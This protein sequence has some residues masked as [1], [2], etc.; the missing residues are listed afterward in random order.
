MSHRQVKASSNILKKSLLDVEN[1]D[2][3]NIS[4]S[5]SHVESEFESE[6]HAVN[7]DMQYKIHS[8]QQTPL[9]TLQQFLADPKLL[10]KPG[11]PTTNI[12]DQYTKRCYN[13]PDKRIDKFMLLT[14]ACRFMSKIELMLNEK[15]NIDSSGIMLD[16]DVYQD[17]EKDQF[18]D[19]I[20]Q[21]LIQH[22]C[23]LFTKILKFTEK[24]TTIYIGIIRRQVI[25]YK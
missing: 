2:L 18:S 14:E 4:V 19:D 8:S 1:H 21:S 11:D 17:D 13:I 6:E 16:F 20:F 15:Q 12:T 3:D 25:T 9:N 10:N 5:N 22:L 24:K 7:S 23:V